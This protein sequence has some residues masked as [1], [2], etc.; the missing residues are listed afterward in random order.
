M[1]RKRPPAG[2]IAADIRSKS[3]STLADSSRAQQSLRNEWFGAFAQAASR[4]AGKP[5]TFIV[6]VLLVIAWG[7]TGPYFHYSDTWQLVINTS[8][9]IITFL[10]VFLIQ[11]TQNRDMLAVQVKLAELIIAAEGAKNKL[12]TAEDMTEE[13]LEALHKQYCNHAET[14]REHLERRRAAKIKQ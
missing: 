13:D 8:T 9:T 3:A 11:N 12:A 5:V 1:A 14:A 2:N 10:M 4:F 6:A 7:A